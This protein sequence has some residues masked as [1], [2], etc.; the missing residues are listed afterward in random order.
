MNLKQSLDKHIN[1]FHIRLSNGLE[2]WAPYIRND[3]HS[4]MGKN[5]PHGVGKSSPEDISGAAEYIISLFPDIDAE[6]LRRKLIDGS[7]PEKN[8]NHKGIECSG[9]VYHVMDR[10]YRDCL[11][12][13][14]VDDLSV[15]KSHVLNGGLK[16]NE[17]KA[18]HQ[19][20]QEEIEEM[21]E[22]VPMR[23]VVDT[24]KRKPQNLCR[25]PGLASDYSSILVDPVDVRIGDL[26]HMQIAGESI[27][28][29][30]IITEISSDSMT[31]AHSARL[32]PEDA[33]GVSLETVPVIE[34]LADLSKL[35]TPRQFLGY[36]RL[37]S[38]GE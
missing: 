33:G 6:S 9:F 38:L 36:R 3:N 12:K 18:A 5:S 10:T 4:E 30:T 20:T 29:I 7:L 13:E 27:P 19:L 26:V 1:E 23:W 17:W 15:P 14:L 31:M 2:F 37:K 35:R 34:G 21:P 22:D 16:F 24:F 8:Y 32:N 28:H 11:N 25:V